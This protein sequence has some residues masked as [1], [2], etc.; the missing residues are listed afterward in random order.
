MLSAKRPKKWPKNAK[1]IRKY[2]DTKMLS[3]HTCIIKL[4]RVHHPSVPQYWLYV[5]QNNNRLS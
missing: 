1:I 4:L 2:L 3:E 5:S